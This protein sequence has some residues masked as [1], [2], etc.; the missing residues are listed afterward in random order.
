MLNDNFKKHSEE[1]PNLMSLTEI[2][3]QLKACKFKDEVGHP[4]ENNIAFIEL[5]DMVKHNR[6]T[7]ITYKG[8]LELPPLDLD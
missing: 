5:E 6:L 1:K 4:L 8:K 7:T 2:I 3:K